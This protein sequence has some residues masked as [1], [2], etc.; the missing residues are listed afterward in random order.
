[1]SSY[2]IPPEVSDNFTQDEIQEYVSQFKEIDEDG[3]GTLDKNE[4]TELMKSLGMEEAATPD[5]VQA[6]IDEV[7]QDGDGVV[8]LSEFFTMMNNATSALKKGLTTKLKD[9]QKKEAAKKKKNRRKK[10]ISERMF[11]KANKNKE[12]ESSDS[13]NPADLTDSEAAIVATFL[14]NEQGGKSFKDLANDVYGNPIEKTKS[15]IDTDDGFTKRKE[16]IFFLDGSSVEV[17]M[18][19]K[20]RLKHVVV[21]VKE[22][23]NLKHD[24]D[25]A[26]YLFRKGALVKALS[27]EDNCFNIL[28]RYDP[29]DSGDLEFIFKRRT[30]LPWSPLSVEAREASD[31]EQGAHRLSFIEAQYRFLNSHFPVKLGQAVEMSAILASSAES[32]PTEDFIFKNIDSFVPEAIV[33]TSSEEQKKHLANRI[34]MQ[35]KRKDFFSG[36]QAIEV[37]K[38]FLAKCQDYYDKMFG[39]TF[40]RVEMVTLPPDNTLT[41]DAVSAKP[42]TKGRCGIGHN[43]IHR[44]S[45]DGKIVT[46]A[47][48]DIVRWLVPEG[49]NI[50]AIWT[51]EEVTFLFTN[52]CEEIQLSLNQY[53]REFLAARD[54]PGKMAH[55][56]R[57]VTEAE[58]RK[59]FDEFDKDKGGTLDRQEMH[60]LLLT[61][62]GLNFNKD[63]LEDFFV[64]VDENNDGEIQFN[65]FLPWYREYNQDTETQKS[66]D[67]PAT[68][69]DNYLSI[70]DH[71]V[72]SKKMPDESSEQCAARL[73]TK[74]FHTFKGIM[75]GSSNVGKTNLVAR[76]SGKEFSD[77][78]NPTLETEYTVIAL[79][80]FKEE[81]ARWIK[82][83]LWDTAGQ[84]KYN[85]V[86]NAYYRGAKGGVAVLV[87]DVNEPKTLKSLENHWMENLFKN[88]DPKD[89]KLTI[90][91]NKCDTMDEDASVGEAFANSKGIPF[92]KV[93]A[94]TDT[95]VLKGFRQSFQKVYTERIKNGKGVESDGGL[96]L[97]GGDGMKSKKKGCC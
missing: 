48:T 53:I 84:E 20:S 93:S 37:E 32:E 15:K 81:E 40:Y 85:A 55:E 5:K 24:N 96:N 26:M 7:D 16:N 58:T 51:E 69:D 17:V 14:E 33:Y 76:L 3:N 95:N 27:D 82:V 45:M 72:R 11:K 65:E 66:N 56:A 9:D 41:T 50:F 59:L 86:M 43:G 70:L 75:L 38:K 57:K 54:T 25:F 18:T 29:E 34:H 35:A 77:S 64:S 97:T 8:N 22:Y 92:C 31:V 47:F 89:A 10:S 36:F 83:E 23:L 62:Y 46:I 71:E 1:M 30:Y 42:K 44:L 80:I 63:E 13:V 52:Q 6:L 74:K 49:Q 87:Y 2:A 21:Q 28:K 39:D 90:L 78:H 79:K 4:M 61:I 19:E 67:A 68:S 91:A 73:L 94:K 88:L 60:A 12:N